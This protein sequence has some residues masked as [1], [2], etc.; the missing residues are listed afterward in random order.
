MYEKAFS[1]KI[2]KK[3]GKPN[4]CSHS[5]VFIK[6]WTS[7]SL[8]HTKQPITHH[9]DSQRRQKQAEQFGQC[10]NNNVHK[11]IKKQTTNVSLLKRSTDICKS[12]TGLN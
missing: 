10:Q 7:V 8:C 11:H 2:L 9:I 3:K 12:Q 6:I 5:V 1:I 4:T